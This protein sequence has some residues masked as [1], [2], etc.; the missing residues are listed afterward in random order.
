[1]INA[2]KSYGV[3]TGEKIV[4]DFIQA[5]RK[6]LRRAE[7]SGHYAKHSLIMLLSC[8]GIL[9]KIYDCFQSAHIPHYQTDRIYMPLHQ[10]I[11]VNGRQS[12]IPHSRI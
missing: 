3:N 4:P 5:A 8:Q 1:M 10:I 7:M 9:L 6:E 11:P 12:M 2:G